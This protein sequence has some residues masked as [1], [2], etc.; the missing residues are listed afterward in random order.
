M[1]LFGNRRRETIHVPFVDWATGKVFAETQMPLDRLPESFEARTTLHLGNDDWD[2]VEA[3]PMTAAEF[4]RTGELVLILNKVRIDQL[5]P[6]EILFSLSTITGEGL[7]PI[8]EGTSKLR[9]DVI[10]IHEDDWRQVEWLPASAL[11]AIESELV[12][13]RTIHEHERRDSGIAKCHMREL[14]RLLRK[15]AIPL[16]KLQSALGERAKWLDGFAY[17]GVAGMVANSFAVRLFSSIELFGVAP[18]GII[19]SVCFA[20]TRA[21][22]AAEPD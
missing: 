18:D 2:V 4:G 17:G 11:D 1:G 19:E 20:N 14:P 13:V 15:K 10:E 21:N 22:H 16:N 7:P 5:D 8:A 6:S 3:R 12:S 9:A